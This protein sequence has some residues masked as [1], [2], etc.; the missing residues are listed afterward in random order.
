VKDSDR[1][2]QEIDVMSKFI[3]TSRWLAL[4]VAL[5]CA[6]CAASAAGSLSGTAIY[7][8]R[9]ALP[10]GAVF[11]AILE[12]VPRA[13]AP[14]NVVATTE[15]KS[16]RTPISFV[17][18]YD[19]QA[20]RPDGRYIVRGRI[21]LNGQ[22]LFA[23]DSD[24]PLQAVG[25][26]HHVELLLRRADADT[27]GISVENTHWKLRTLHGVVVTPV[28]PTREAWLM[29]DPA[30]HRASGFAGCNRFTGDYTLEGDRL[31]FSHMATT[32]QMCLQGMEQE[33]ALL[34]ALPAVARWRVTGT[35]LA[36]LDHDGGVTATFDAGTGP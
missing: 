18:A 13:N 28:E 7:R 22:V 15:V 4:I 19:D 21:A 6:G 25:G 34:N 32:L 3:L 26:V 24:V 10:P 33:Q 12:E 2:D 31:S 36:L 23:T 9:M 14:V 8:E 27:A 29:L 35:Q 17:L 30:G 16:S 20:I 5:A 1:A 11:E